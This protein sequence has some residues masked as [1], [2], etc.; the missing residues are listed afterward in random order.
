MSENSGILVYSS[1]GSPSNRADAGT[2]W[3]DGMPNSFG[4][5]SLANYNY[6]I[7]A[8]YIP[9]NN[10][11][12]PVT[13]PV[14]NICNEDLSDKYSVDGIPAYSNS[15]CN[16]SNFNVFSDNG[17]NTSNQNKS[18]W[19]QT[20][21]GGGYQC[22]EFATRYLYFKW[23]IQSVPNGNAGQWLDGTLPA[24][25]T[26]ATRPVHGDIAVFKSGTYGHVAV[27][28][29]VSSS[30]IT[31][32]EQNFNNGRNRRTINASEAD[33]FLHVTANTDY[34]QPIPVQE[35]L[36]SDG[37][38]NDLSEDNVTQT[39]QVF[40]HSDRIT[41]YPNP[42]TTQIVLNY[43]GQKYNKVKFVCISGREV[44]RVDIGYGDNTIDISDLAKGI[45]FIS[46]VNAC[47]SDFQQKIIIE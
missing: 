20:Q 8:N 42:A 47:T 29:E 40:S 46:F 43:E 33:G 36:V 41:I 6:S 26:I 13:S 37:E 7:Y 5:S 19:K 16:N 27:V 28:D 17:V 38:N 18:G 12:D 23:N 25:L 39:E 32:V 31:I 1:T 22:T 30:Q 2:G 10:T 9:D 34:N 3:S 24:G 11:T 35:P 21:Y 4:S 15:K 45:Y 14:D 44:K